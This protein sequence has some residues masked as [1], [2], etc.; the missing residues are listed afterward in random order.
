MSSVV[1][2]KKLKAWELGTLE[3]DGGPGRIDD[4]T[5]EEDHPLK[6]NHLDQWEVEGGSIPPN[7]PPVRG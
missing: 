2:E 3:D 5:T 4:D 6:V 1:D 7:D